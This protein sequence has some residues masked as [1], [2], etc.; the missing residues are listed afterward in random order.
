[1]GTLKTT[2]K[3]ESTDLFPTPV[4]FTN[5]NNNQVNGDFSGFNQVIPVLLPAVTILN[6]AAIS[7]SAYV[8]VQAPSSNT[9]TVVVW[10]ENNAGTDGPIQVATLAAGDVG[11]FPYGGVENLLATGNGT[12]RLYFFV[13]EKS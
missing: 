8:Y 12:D 2:L 7:T 3:V 6:I 13:G 9:G 11:F 1:M 5:V 10:N 4:S